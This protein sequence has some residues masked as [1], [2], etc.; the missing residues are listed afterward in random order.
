MYIIDSSVWISLFL[1]FDVNH[2]EAVIIFEEISN[3]KIVLP[4]CIINEVCSVLT[5][6]WSKKIANSFLD[7]IDDNEDIF[8]ENNFVHSEIDFFYDLYYKVSF[9]DLSI[10]KIAIDKSLDLITFDKQMAS[11]YK[12]LN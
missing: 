10:I 6:K 12:K 9:T 8:I 7:F 5:Y 11:I 4:Y 1:D 3:K 2:L